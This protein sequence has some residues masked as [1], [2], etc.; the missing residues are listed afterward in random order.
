MMHFALYGNI[1]A[2]IILWFVNIVV[3]GEW[4]LTCYDDQLKIDCDYSEK[5]VIHEAQFGYFHTSVK[6]KEL[7]HLCTTHQD[8]D[9]WA[10]VTA[11][12]SRLC[13]GHRSCIKTVHYS[14]DLPHEFITKKCPVNTEGSKPSLFVEYSCIS[15]TLFTNLDG[16]NHM[17][18][19][20]QVG[21][22]LTTIDYTE[23]QNTG[24]EWRSHLAEAICQ[25]GNEQLPYRFFLP[26][27]S[28]LSRPAFGHE[29]AVSFVLR[30]K[31][32]SFTQPFVGIGE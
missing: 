20:E 1:S 7:E 4:N 10:E 17:V 26:T 5:I 31:D 15:T 14:I 27:P 8:S 29:E 13:S 12:I 18:D 28:T 24:T 6:Q 2:V 22:Y 11:S 25:P 3:S 19:A 16:S 32:L 23:T 21:G 30:V 9:C